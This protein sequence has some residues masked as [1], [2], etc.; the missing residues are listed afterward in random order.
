MNTL[1]RW[2]KIRCQDTSSLISERMDHSLP[3]SKRLRVGMHLAMCKACRI[4][5]QQ[6][7]TV[8]S[9]ARKLGREEDPLGPNVTM[10]E[11]CKESIKAVL[12]KHQGS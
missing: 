9:L 4:Y 10:T 11:D 1:T 8:R 3:L 12:K 7:Q 5:E 2:L 6:L